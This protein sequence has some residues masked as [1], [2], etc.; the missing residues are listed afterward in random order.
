MDKTIPLRLHYR[1]MSM[2]DVGRVPID[3]QGTLEDVRRR[4]EELGA[5]AML[6][7]Q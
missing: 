5:S 6:V 7:F 3:C 1:P 2:A 4:I